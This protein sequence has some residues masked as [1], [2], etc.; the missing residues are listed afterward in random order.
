MAIFECKYC[1]Q[2]FVKEGVFNNH[3]CEEMKRSEFIKTPKG[4]AA[5]FY[6]KEWLQVSRGNTVASEE[7]F[8]S[9]RYYTSFLKFLE[10]SNKMLLPNKSAFIKY[11]AS[12]TIL[13]VHW[14][15]DEVYISYI[16]NLDKV[17]T[18]VE[19]AQETVKT[20][21]ELASGFGCQAHEV[22]NYLEA[23]DCVKLLKARRLT[24]WV[25]MFSRRFHQFLAIKL[26]KEQRIIIQSSINPIIWKNKFQNRPLDVEK[27]KSVVAQ[28]NL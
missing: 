1:N 3:H 19:Q 6:Y 7:T 15:N 4:I 23:G 17:Y 16:E 14:C 10:F 24:P 21:Y 13:P 27:M 18:P 28:L 12:K 26:S 11:V 25:L 9:S 22:F 2:K 5:F 20:M 8:I